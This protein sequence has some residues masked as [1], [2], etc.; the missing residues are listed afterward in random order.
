MSRGDSTSIDSGL[1]EKSPSQHLA[2]QTAVACLIAI[3][4]Y[5]ALELIVVCFSTFKRYGG[6]YFW[7][8]LIASSSII[9]FSLGYLL[10]IYN[11]YTNLFPVAMELVAWVGMVTGQSLVLWSRLHLVVQNH[12]LLRWTLAMI[13][14]DTI[15]FHIP[16]SVLELG[17]HT[18]KQ[19][20]F[21]RAFNI[22]ERIQLIG[23]SIQETILSLIYSWEA[24]RMLKLRPRAHFRSILVQLLVI[25][26]AMIIMDAA[27]IGAQYTGYFDVHVTLKAMV[28]SVKLKLEYA[29]LGKLVH[30]AEMG[31][32]TSQPSDLSDYVDLTYNTG[33]RPARTYSQGRR[34]DRDVE[35]IHMSS[36]DY[37]PPRGR[38]KSHGVPSSSAEALT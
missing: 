37:T 3:G 17:S 15:I 32:T 35:H 20:L 27:V 30:Y 4:W 1:S 22:F 23:F 31:R 14:V 13:I 18:D 8:L 7:S 36:K 12:N 25:N 21:D 24:V 11:V 29:I 33:Q 28:Y 16:G 34:S 26:L 2:E 10:I 6:L 9:P 5:N 38:W 19:Y